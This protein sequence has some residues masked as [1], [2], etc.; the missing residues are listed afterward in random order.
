MLNIKEASFSAPFW[1][2]N[3]HV[4][5]L[6]GTLKFRRPALLKKS[7]ALLEHCEEMILDAGTVDGEQVQLQSYYSPAKDKHA[8]LVI[9]LHGWEGSHESLYML[10]TANYLHAKGC[11][12]L[13]LNLRDH[14]SSHHLNEEIFHSNR[15]Q[16]VI[17]AVKT[18]A[19]QFSY[20]KLF[21]VGFSLGGNFSCRI[22][23]EADKNQLKLDKV[24]AICPAINPKNILVQLEN[25][26]FFYHDYFIKKWKRS[27]KKKQQ[28]FPEKYNFDNI[29]E[30]KSMRQMT[31]DLVDLFGQYESINHYF[32][33][34]SLAGERL[35]SI[36]I[37][38]TILLT[39]DDPI[40][41]YDDIKSVSQ[42]QHLTIYQSQHGGHCGFIKNISLESWCDEFI[43]QQI[44]P[45]L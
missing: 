39:Q 11:Q 45:Y 17:N 34:Y 33:G 7:R 15:L 18:A 37:P 5:S 14:G 10:S 13:R 27:L 36:T 29:Y 30:Q 32:E 4:Q 41:I 12:I 31:V 16:E 22:A 44:T 38:T 8:P 28:L 43:W 3:Q 21:L 26:L 40:I 19:T 42:N 1:A 25:G 23:A 20:S 35:S 24:V 9:M 6:L 2:K